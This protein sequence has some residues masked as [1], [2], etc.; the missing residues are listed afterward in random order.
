MDGQDRGYRTA[1]LIDD[2]AA[3][4]KRGFM[5]FLKKIADQGY[6]RVLVTQLRAD[7][8]LTKD[9]K[10][11]HDFLKLLK[12]A[13][14]VTVACIGV[15]SAAD[16][17]LEAV[18]KNVDAQRMA[19]ALKAM[20]RAGIV[21][22]GMFIAFNSD[23]RETIRRNGEY[24]RKYV[25]SLQYLFETPLPGTKR[26]REHEAA[27]AILF[28]ELEDLSFYDGMHC[29]LRPRNMSPVEMQQLVEREDERFYSRGRIVLSALSGLFTRFRILNVG[30]RA[31]LRQLSPLRRIRTWA[32]FHAEYK[33]APVANLVVGRRRLLQM[34]QD[35]RHTAFMNRLTTLEAAE[36]P[37]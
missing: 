19:R 2:N 17:S 23:A 8:V 10:V 18:H 15:E 24:A 36:S 35:P 32:V 5:E 37:R 25:H 11:D 16:E 27:G 34:R 1:F 26:T 6:A 7:S 3:A 12:R 21:V 30:Q 13:A 31:F 4:N 29:I 22:H 9:G 20:R 33:F 28:E 14:G